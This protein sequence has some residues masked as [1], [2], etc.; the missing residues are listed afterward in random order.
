[1]SKRL[2]IETSVH[3]KSI[4]DCIAHK[5]QCTL[6]ST[7]HGGRMTRKNVIASYIIVVLSKKLL[8][9]LRIRTGKNFWQINLDQ[10]GWRCPWRTIFWFHYFWITVTTRYRKR[11]HLEIL[12][13]ANHVSS[14]LPRD[15]IEITQCRNEC[16]ETKA[17]AITRCGFM[18]VD[19]PIN[20][21][22]DEV[23]YIY[24]SGCKAGKMHAIEFCR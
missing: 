17:S 22:E 5:M 2:C 11:L 15:W 24:S 3:L 13:L 8:Y 14:K 19:N 18:N 1:M 4:P 10:Q 16:H 23:K 7:Q 12:G 21:S 9:F 6:G 20:Q